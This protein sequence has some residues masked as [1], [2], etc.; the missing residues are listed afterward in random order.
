MR[1]LVT[2][3]TGFIG[4]HLVARLLSEGHAV[5]VLDERGPGT[6]PPQAP[7]TYV[8]GDVRDRS[9]VWKILGD[10]DAVFHLAAVVG[11]PHAISHQ[12]DSLTTAALGTVHILEA[13]RERDVPVFLA[14][15][16]AI[17]GK[18]WG[19]RLGE[20]R[21]V[22]LGNTHRPAWTY[23]YAKLTE[24]LLGRAAATEWGCRVVVGRLFNVIGPYQSAAYGAV[25]PRF[26]ERALA[27]LPLDVYGDGSQTRTFADVRDA[28]EGILTV[29]TRGTSGQVYNIGGTD[30]T[31]I[32]DLARMVVSLSG[33][34][35]P[36]RTVPFD[37]VFDAMFEE[38]FRRAPSLKRL[39]ALGYW[40]RYTLADSLREII[41][42]Y[43]AARGQA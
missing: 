26:V 3:G 1:V 2:G 27:G 16:S 21:E 42:H 24:E 33:S 29:W 34:R 15:S 30:E 28:V 9:L 36:I 37:Q 32:V 10:Q 17:Y 19:G 7:A 31:R 40:P 22:R 14:S 39:S 43:R 11:V 38:P 35:S 5:T 12:W 23:S 6:R 13:V 20:E 41:A 18:S 8:Q 25:V 4:S